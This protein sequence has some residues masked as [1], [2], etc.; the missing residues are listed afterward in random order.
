MLLPALGASFGKMVPAVVL[1]FAALRFATSG[2]YQL[3]GSTTWEH[4]SGWIGVVLGVLAIYAALAALLENVRGRT[5]LP[6]GRRQKGKM[7]A[8][9]GFAE[10]VIDVTHEPG[11]RSQL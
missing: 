8:E 1:A 10:Q 11:V 9:G 6:L 4:I 2:V 7:A 5:V 3:N